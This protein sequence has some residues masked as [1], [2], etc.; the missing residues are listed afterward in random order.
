MYL[1]FAQLGTLS[2]GFLH[3]RYLQGSGIYEADYPWLYALLFRYKV[4]LFLIAAIITLWWTVYR[5][6]TFTLRYQINQL[7]LLV[8][9]VMLCITAGPGLATSS[10]FGRFWLFI[11]F[12]SVAINDAAAFFVGK[13]FGKHKLIQLS[14]NKT[15]EGFLGGI[16]INII[17][18]YIWIGMMLDGDSMKFW[19]CPNTTYDLS[20]FKD[21]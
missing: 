10:S 9:V 2:Q 20:P 18:T 14:P 15:W 4:H 12:V 11:P 5:M 7:G 1:I 3:W 8:F 16:V 21:V 6:D 17:M 13:F 19:V